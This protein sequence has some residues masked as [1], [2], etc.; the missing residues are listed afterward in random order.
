MVKVQ[1]NGVHGIIDIIDIEGEAMMRIS[2]QEERRRMH[3]K[4]RTMTLDIRD[5]TITAEV[6]TMIRILTENDIR[7]G[8]NMK[9]KIVYKYSTI[10]PDGSDI[11]QFLLWQDDKVKRTTKGEA[12]YRFPYYSEDPFVV[13]EICPE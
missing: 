13:D 11:E 3:S 5:A 2:V 6:D 4:T 12:I 9:G 8:G 7:L 1:D 10:P